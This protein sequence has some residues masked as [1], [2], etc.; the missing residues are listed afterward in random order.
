MLSLH[1]CCPHA[2]ALMQRHTRAQQHAPIH[3]TLMTRKTMPSMIQHTSAAPITTFTGF[4]DGAP[5]PPAIAVT[6]YTV[7]LP[8]CPASRKV[9]SP[10]PSPPLCLSLSLCL[11]LPLSLPLSLFALAISGTIVFNMPRV[12]VVTWQRT[13]PLPDLDAHIWPQYSPCMHQYSPYMV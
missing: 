11:P 6:N 9:K 8:F 10:P 4:S 13:D 12:H 1:Q 3:A 5:L 2:C 7:L